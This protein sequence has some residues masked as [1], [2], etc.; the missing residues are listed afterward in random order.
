MVWLINERIK[1]SSSYRFPYNIK[2]FLSPRAWLGLIKHKRQRVRQ[3][4]SGRDTWGGGEHIMEITGGILRFI[5]E[6]GVVDWDHYF[7][8]NYEDNYGY[9]SLSEVADDLENY[10]YFQEHLF[11]DEEIDSD[12]RW[13]IEYQLYEQAKNAMHFVAANIGGLWW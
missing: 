9:S 7:E 8:A 10:L 5:E 2:E 11:E 4:W 1:E 12:T 13:A 6:Q 3:G